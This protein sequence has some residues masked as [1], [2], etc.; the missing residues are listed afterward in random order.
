M[1][2]GADA[3]RRV[4]LPAIDHRSQSSEHPVM[5]FADNGPSGLFDGSMNTIIRRGRPGKQYP[6]LRISPRMLDARQAII[7]ISEE[8]RP[9][10]AL[11]V[12]ARSVTFR[13]DGSQQTA[14][15]V[16]GIDPRP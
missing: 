13:L 15:P 8:A 10:H 9:G 6:A 2:L 4:T 7:D 11:I 5:K 14:A 12:G 1:C 3:R 16:R